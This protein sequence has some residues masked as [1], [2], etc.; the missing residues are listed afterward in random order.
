M[1]RIRDYTLGEAQEICQSRDKCTGCVLDLDNAC[2]IG[3]CRRPDLF[4]LT[5]RPH[6][7]P[8]EVEDAQVLM[9][10]FGYSG[11]SKIKRLSANELWVEGGVDERVWAR[12]LQ[13][14]AFPSIA[15]GEVYTL[16]EILGEEDTNDAGN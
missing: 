4:D 16:D 13:L 7:T 12:R 15:V 6:F 3:F 11:N 1:K 8:Q 10:L 14:S 9:R 2:R 5:D